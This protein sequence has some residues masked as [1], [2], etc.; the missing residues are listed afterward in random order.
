MRVRTQR[1]ELLRLVQRLFPLEC[2]KIVTD[3][4]EEPG[5]SGISNKQGVE[6][7]G[8]SSSARLLKQSFS[9]ND[10]HLVDQDVTVTRVGRTIK[11]PSR[12]LE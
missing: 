11:V 10:K 1:G 5:G 8:E 9:E 6:H 2:D 7:V 12:F 3:V 4:L